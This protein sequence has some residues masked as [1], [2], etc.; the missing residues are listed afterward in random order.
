MEKSRDTVTA[1][2]RR[3]AMAK[4]KED[5]IRVIEMTEVPETLLDNGTFNWKSCKTSAFCYL[6][7]AV[8]HAY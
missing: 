8:C 2:S 4:L 6:F 5:G 7:K 1:A 3:E